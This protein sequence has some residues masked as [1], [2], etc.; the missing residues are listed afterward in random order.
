MHPKVI[1]PILLLT[2]VGMDLFGLCGHYATT[3]NR[4]Q[5]LLSRCSGEDITTEMTATYLSRWCG[6]ILLGRRCVLSMEEGN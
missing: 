2:T 6:Y 1:T 5:G 3:D 4:Q